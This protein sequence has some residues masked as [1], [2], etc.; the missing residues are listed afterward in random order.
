M[1]YKSK[2]AKFAEVITVEKTQLKFYLLAERLDDIT[3]DDI[4]KAKKTIADHSEI[5]KN[6]DEMGFAILHRCGENYLL[7]VCSFRNENEIWETVYYDGS[8]KFEVWDRK[9]PHLPTFCVWEMNIAYHESQ[10]YKT[11]LGSA[12]DEKAKED[13]LKAVFKGTV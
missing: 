13:Y 5:F 9:L 6:A 1:A 10:A 4:S 7:L 8:G 12:M 3:A 2:H 11:F